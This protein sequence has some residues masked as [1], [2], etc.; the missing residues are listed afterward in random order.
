MTSIALSHSDRLVRDGLLHT[1]TA[2]PTISCQWSQ[3]N[4]FL[5]NKWTAKVDAKVDVRGIRSHVYAY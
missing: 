1:Y 4:H 3:G 2:D 5:C